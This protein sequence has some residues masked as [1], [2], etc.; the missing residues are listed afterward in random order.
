MLTA[1]GIWGAVHEP[2][3][4]GPF[5]AGVLEDSPAILTNIDMFDALHAA[6]DMI[7]VAGGQAGFGPRAINITLT[8]VRSREGHAT[9]NSQP[10][11][12]LTS[13]QQVR[14]AACGVGH[15]HSCGQ[16]H[17]NVTL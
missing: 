11:T 9:L 15:G 3:E 12:I 8:E 5:N 1:S 14:R 6:P 7:T 17:T 10:P 4:S 16:P 2:A 13:S